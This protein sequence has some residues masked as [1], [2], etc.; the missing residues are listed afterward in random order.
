MLE[1]LNLT[2]NF[3]GEEPFI[4]EAA[5]GEQMVSLVAQDLPDLAFVDIRMPQLNGLEAIR[6]G[7]L[8][9]PHTNWIILTG[10][11]EFDY[12]KE[13][14]QLGV[15]DYL[16]KPVSLE[17]LG[18]IISDF[19]E[20]NKKQVAAQ[21]KQ[22]ERD[23]MALHYGLAAYDFEEPE[24]QLP[25]SHYI[26]AIL[27][28]DSHLEE[29]KKADR[30][31]KLKRAL[32]VCIEKHSGTHN[33]LALLVLPSGEL[34]SIGACLLHRNHQPEYQLR[35]YFRDLEQTAAR[36]NSLEFAVTVL[37]S[38]EC[39]SL[40]ALQ[41]QLERMQ[42][43]APFRVVCGV[44]QSLSLR[45]LLLQSE[46]PDQ[47]E[48]SGQLLRVSRYYQEKNALSLSKALQNLEEALASSRLDRH[49]TL[50]KAISDFLSYSIGCSL[51]VDQN[52]DSWKLALQ[53][54]GQRM[55]SEI[56]REEIPGADIIQQVLKY[57]EANY[58]QE[59]G[60]GLIAERLN[61]TPNYL[62]T[63]FHKRTGTNFMSYLKQVRLLK[64][65]QLLANPNLQIQQVA[66]RVGYFSPRHFARLFAEQFGC[67][68]SEY[69]EQLKDN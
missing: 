41:D 52:L 55:L 5:N 53:R 38:E 22:F 8:A 61:I 45:A 27:L 12:A 48:L 58:N 31:L 54:Y 32:Q 30:L 24:N 36:F 67:L 62:S 65:K 66:E 18:R 50:K 10:F 20:K 9:S 16:L 57:I 2:L 13:A 15:S 49:R 47:S 7:K 56:P 40:T 68:P 69:R 42:H 35:T 51:P 19:L 33:R 26:G 11:P 46:R 60:I 39:S 4:L 6:M 63:L 64:A 21:N 44:G 34:A 43:L 3:S 28:F 59:I 1:E 29:K 14:I 23:M 17:E 37:I 25:Y